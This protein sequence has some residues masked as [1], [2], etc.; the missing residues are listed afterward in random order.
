M[1]LF[2]N[3]FGRKAT[4]LT[5]DQIADRLDGMSGGVVAGVAVT[6]KT[7]LEVSTVLACVKV[8]AD[9]VATPELKVFREKAGG[10]RELAT[11]IPEYRLLNRRPNEWQTSF[12]WRRQMTIHAALTGAGL[13]LK[14]RGSN[15]RV[16][17]LIPV[18]PGQWDV[19][20]VSRYEVR[21]RC[22]DEFGLI[23]EFA[24]DDVFVI[25][26]V[27]W[28]WA[29]SLNAVALARSAIGLAMATERSQ[30]SMHANGLR[31][32]G[33][34]SVEGNL[35]PE[36][37]DRLTTWLKNKGGPENAG[38]PLV[39]DRSAKW[40]NTGM[41]GVDA[42]HVETRRLQIEEICRGYGVFPIMVGHSDKS[43]TFASSEAF[44]AAHLIHTLAP[45]HRAWT[46]RMDEMLL[47]GAGPLWAEFDTRYMRMGSMADRAQ[48]ARTMVEMGLLSPN[49][50]RDEEGRD[51]R[52]G[53]NEYLRPMNMAAG[54]DTQPAPAE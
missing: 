16:R 40:L 4:Q 24:P 42:Q 43:S 11:N 17:E 37:H 45:W 48:Y 10:T 53:G 28:D 29:K 6:E 36:Q 20:K 46:Q 32:S 38:T 47:D 34:Y 54:S 12:E 2:G 41:S 26:G 13:S 52:E 27:Q 18:Q 19:R 5:Y 25:N 1:K 22:W 21:Y 15:N 44:F 50:W 3:L 31:P 8:I 23:G 9:G 35:T 14:V 30:Q 51:P 7:A 49:E 39:L 33:T